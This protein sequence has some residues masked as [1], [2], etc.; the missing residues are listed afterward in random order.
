MNKQNENLRLRAI[1][2]KK[3][4]LIEMKSVRGADIMRVPMIILVNKTKTKDV[5]FGVMEHHRGS[6][7]IDSEARLL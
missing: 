1:P 3:L 7:R 2:L 5:L 4:N 6:Q